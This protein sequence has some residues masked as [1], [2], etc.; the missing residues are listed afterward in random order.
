MAASDPCS[1]ATV[2]NVTFLGLNR[3]RGDAVRRRVAARRR[4]RVERVRQ[5]CRRDDGAPV[6]REVLGE[7]P[8]VERVRRGRRRERRVDVALV[9]DAAA[10]LPAANPDVDVVRHADRR[11]RRCAQ[12]AQRIALVGEAG[13]RADAAARHRAVEPLLHRRRGRCRTTRAECSCTDA[14][15]TV[16]PEDTIAQSKKSSFTT[17][18]RGRCLSVVSRGGTLRSGSFHCRVWAMLA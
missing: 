15:T 17:D 11:H 8:A 6:G 13:R 4:G 12:R 2:V 3:A 1:G 18:I 7:H 10:P 5:R 9:D 16:T 14:T